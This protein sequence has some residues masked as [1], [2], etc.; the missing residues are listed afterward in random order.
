M[1]PRFV[2]IRNPKS[3]CFVLIDRLFGMIIGNSDPDR[4]F[5]RISI[6]S[7]GGKHAGTQEERTPQEVHRSL[8]QLRAPP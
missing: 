7:I 5:H 4:P 6:R 2:Q 1:R 3:G 8:N